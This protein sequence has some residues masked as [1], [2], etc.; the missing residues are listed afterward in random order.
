MQ[1][2]TKREKM[3]VFW[4]YVLGEWESI[5]ILSLCDLSSGV[6]VMFRVR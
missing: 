6:S 1:E 2:G 5:A 4:L 3:L